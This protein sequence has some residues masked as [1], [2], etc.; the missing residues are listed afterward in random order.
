MGRR[1]ATPAVQN[2]VRAVRVQR[3]FS[4]QALAARAG[5]TRQ[6]LSAIESGQYVPNTAVALA[7]ARA[8]G[9]RVEDLFLLPES[10]RAFAIDLVAPPPPDVGRLAV[11]QVRGRWIGYP[12]AAE[13]GL[14]DGFVSA[15]G[16]L[17]PDDGPARAELLT[18]SEV[19]ERTALL[20]GCDPSL[21]ILAAHLARYQR[22]VRLLW[23]PATSQAALDALANGRAHVGGTHL[24]DPD[25]EEHN[26][27]QARAALRSIGGV[28]V[29]FARW[30]QGLVVAPGNPK[31]LRGVEDLARPDVRLINREPGAGTRRLLDELLARAGVPPRAVSGY[32]RLA[33]SHLAVARTV[34][35][36]SADVGVALRATA[37]ALGLDFVPLAEARF[38]LVI[39]RD[40]LQHPAVALLLDVLQSRP[41][42]AELAALPGYDVSATGTVIADLPAA[43]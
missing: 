27:P 31:G 1:I 36:G 10:A 32:E 38:D 37:R 18:A 25:S 39:P 11:V 19:L 34:A 30:E 21:G 6:A 29:A 16:L 33:P 4:Q 28:V 9:C 17:R 20:L 43:A 41:L 42:R 7:L 15:D 14:Y 2:R 12:L 24:R 8:L 23:L 3:G 13:L 22:E 40:H 35:Q 5:L 26:V